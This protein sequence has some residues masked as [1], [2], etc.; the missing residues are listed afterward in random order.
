MTT[1][2]NLAGSMGATMLD[3]TPNTAAAAANAIKRKHPN[4][5]KG[6]DGELNDEEGVHN[7]DNQSDAHAANPANNPSLAHQSAQTATHPVNGYQPDNPHTQ[8]TCRGLSP[9]EPT[10]SHIAY[11]KATYLRVVKSLDSLLTEIMEAT[12]DTIRA[13]SDKYIALLMYGG[14]NKV[15]EENPNLTN[16]IENFLLGLTITGNERIHVVDPPK[17]KHGQEGRIEGRKIAFSAHLFDTN[18]RPWFIMDIVG[19]AVCDDPEAI[20]EGLMTITP[21]LAKDTNFRNHVNACLAKVENPRSI[22][23][24][25]QDTLKSFEMYSMRITNRE[26]KETTVWQ[27]F[28]NPIANNG[29][30]FKEWLRIIMF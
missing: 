13:N 10:Q 18:V 8:M 15:K 11:T 7:G 4:I 28:T 26:K 19:Q 16:N 30:E 27:L 5:L 20:R 23:E 29:L 21:A 14:G 24:H 2:P 9:L 17:K 1:G 3:P 12:A 22:D 6:E 25:V